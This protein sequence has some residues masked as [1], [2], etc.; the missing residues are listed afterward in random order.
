MEGKGRTDK[1][2][3]CFSVSKFYICISLK[4]SPLSA[5][6]LTPRMCHQAREGR[7][8]KCVVT[9]L[10]SESFNLKVHISVHVIGVETYFAITDH[11]P[12]FK[13]DL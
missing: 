13:A 1:L 3:G 4:P 2:D 11:V 9:V 8:V 6:L 12:N 7:A 5:K 10:Y